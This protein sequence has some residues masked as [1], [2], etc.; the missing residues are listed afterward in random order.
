MYQKIVKKIGDNH[1]YDAIK[2]TTACALP[3]LFFNTKETFPVAFTL[4]MGAMLTAPVD[5]ASSLKHKVLGLLLGSFTI[6]AITLILGT[7][8]H[9]PWIFYPLFVFIIFSVSMIGVYGQRANLLSFTALLSISL[10]FIHDYEG[11]DLWMNCLYL[12]L[13]GLLYLVVSLLFYLLQP[14]RYIIIEIANCIEITAD[15]LD[16]R[17]QLW[18]ADADRDKIIKEQLNLQVKLN[19]LHESIRE[20]LIHHKAHTYNTNN[21]R[22][23]LISL[24][25]LI[26]MME[27]TN[28]N[29][30]NHEQIRSLYKNDISVIHRYQKLA[31]HM[32]A[33]LH[34]LSYHIKANK[35]YHSP[36]SLNKDFK[37]LKQQF[38]HFKQQNHL[39]NHSDEITIFSNVL[40]YAEKQIEK[41]KGLERVYKGRVNADE[42]GGKYKDLEKFLTP[43][44]YR[45]A[46]LKENLTPSSMI[47]R[48]SARLTLTLLLGYVLGKLLPLQNEYWILM[49]MVVIMRPG[50]GLT[51]QRSKE[52]VLGTIFGGFLAF[53]FLF[54][55]H[56]TPFLVVLTILSMIAGYWLSYS[57][58]KIGVTFITIYVVLIYGMLTPNYESLLIYR[59]I[60]TAIG[61]FLA[62]STTHLLWPSWE[63]LKIKTHLKESISSNKKYV[64]EIK[65]YYNEKGEP[66]TSYKLARKHAFIEVGNLMASFQRMIQEPK[67]KQ[68]NK[69]ELYELAVLNQTLVSAAAS[70]GTYVQSHSTTEA[71]RAFNIVMNKVIENLE[72]TLQLFDKNSEVTVSEKEEDFEVSFS[73][74]KSIRTYEVDLT[75]TDEEKKRQLI[76]ESQLVID[77]LIWMVSLSEKILRISTKIKIERQKNKDE[78]RLKQAF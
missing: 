30:F 75:E 9:F 21:N 60:D 10:A 74:L 54:F 29:A 76:E 37:A 25:S 17:A 57:Q 47:F 49:T 36:V 51:K 53:T 34:A 72:Q 52:R 42:L 35:K 48:H 56:H 73:K 55:V 78:K 15:Y 13:G 11:Y 71:S 66:K 43:Q 69:A 44:H 23:L 39:H 3:F 12:F 19:E 70:I 38:E 24:S 33:T 6:A 63:F 68:K 61:A 28:A 50:Y 41:I 27:L 32:A 62:F 58:Y 45:L 1:L 2:I 20:Y 8:V 5:I 65:L 67:S 22:K 26:D 46:I 59:I 16:L 14:H 31:E 4:A 64:Q 7:T 40:H 77:Q 18:S